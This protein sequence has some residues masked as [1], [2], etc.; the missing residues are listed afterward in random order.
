MAP[1]RS[2]LRVVAAAWLSVLLA[3]STASAQAPRARRPPVLNNN[4]E[5]RP[6]RAEPDRWSHASENLL[7]AGPVAGLPLP[8]PSSVDARLRPAAARQLAT[9]RSRVRALRSTRVRPGSRGAMWARWE[10]MEREAM[11]L[12]SLS[13][14]IAAA[15]DPAP[16]VEAL[17]LVGDAFEHLSTEINRAYFYAPPRVFTCGNAL[18]NEELEGVLQELYSSPTPRPDLALRARRIA[19]EELARP[20]REAAE[21]RR[22]GPSA[23]DLDGP[24]FPPS[25]M[26][27]EVALVFFATAFH[28]SLAHPSHVPVAWHAL[29]RMQGESNRFILDEALQHQTLVTD[30]GSWA[31]LVP[32]GETLL[33]RSPLGPVALAP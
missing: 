5:F 10:A 22:R 15:R 16:T 17:T 9:L 7:S 32:P 18:R 31:A 24:H 3:A 26:T 30:H 25:R 8:E 23:D 11:A 29:D 12:L 2:G 4:A 33:E 19:Q 14:R 6:L 13:R 21:R 20:A 28:L 1:L 27:S